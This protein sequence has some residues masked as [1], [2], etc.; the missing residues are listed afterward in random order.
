[1]VENEGI[2]KQTSDLM[3]EFGGR[4]DA[5]V[6]LVKESCNEEELN[7]YRRAVGAIMAEM[8]LQV[9]NPLYRRHPDLKPAGLK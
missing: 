2:A 7:G 6:A 9:M 1:M 5:S 8:L 3:L 4:L